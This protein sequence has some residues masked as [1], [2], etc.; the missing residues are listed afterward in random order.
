MSH[1]GWI[2]PLFV[3]ATRPERFAKAA[4]S[5]ADAIIVDLEDAVDPAD[6]DAARRNVRA[7]VGAG[8][9]V[10]LRINSAG[11]RWFDEDLLAARDAGVQ[12]VM[13]PKSERVEDLTDA[14][15]KSGL[16][17]VALIETISALKELDAL[18]MA[19][20]VVQL[21]FGTMDLA[22]E[23][24]CAPESR[25][26]DTVRLDLLIS[27]AKSGLAPPLDGVSLAVSD[28][29]R[30]EEEAAVV[31]RNGFA[32]RMLIHPAQVMPTARGMMP[33]PD[34]LSWS[35]EVCASSGAAVRVGGR[36]V[37]RPVRLNAERL[38]ERAERVSRVL[39]GAPAK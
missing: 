20:G 26:L 18:C 38:V 16:P 37:D 35:A 25:L 27:S 21:A 1:P 33:A 4:E 22:S 12:A 2:L 11:S 39:R 31:A 7:A 6:K 23:L 17:L 30:L 14:H 8:A 34:L 3:P 9:D 10:I 29:E 19:R 15:A 5:G 36:M 13:L 24:G 32:G 28:L